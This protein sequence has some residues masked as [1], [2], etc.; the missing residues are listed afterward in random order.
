[1]AQG[2]PTVFNQQDPLAALRDIHVPEGIETWPP[3][4][5]WWMLAALAL[6]LLA[7]TAVWFYRRWRQNRYRREALGELKRIFEA[8]GNDPQAYLLEYATLLKRV[9]LTRY[10]RERVAGLT[11]ERWTRFLDDTAGTNEF[12]MGAGQALIEGAYAPAADADVV[13]LQEIGEHW[14][15]Q[16]GETEAAA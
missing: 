1:M 7:G 16:H 15:R 8:Y 14:I 13:R 11:G 12:T 3:A 2:N 9:A 5:G 4:P 6:I 10:P